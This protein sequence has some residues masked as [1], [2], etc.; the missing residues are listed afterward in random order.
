M[1][2]NDLRRCSIRHATRQLVQQRARADRAM[3]G[4]RCC[5]SAA[6]TRRRECLRSNDLRRGSIH[7]AHGSPPHDDRHACSTNR[8]ALD[9]RHV[10]RNHTRGRSLSEPLGPR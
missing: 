5:S 8:R 9:E 1:R 3:R 7:H 10:R 2:S 6:R 4:K